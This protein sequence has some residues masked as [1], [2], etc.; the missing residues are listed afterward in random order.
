MN[1]AEKASIRDNE[2]TVVWS[3]LVDIIF[4]KTNLHPRQ[5]NFERYG[6]WG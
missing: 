4:E 6:D 3:D 2:S 1:E 5:M